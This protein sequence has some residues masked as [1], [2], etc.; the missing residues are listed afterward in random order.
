[1][2]NHLDKCKSD[3]LFV[4]DGMAACARASEQLAYRFARVG[5]RFGQDVRGP[6][7]DRGLDDPD[8]FES[9]VLRA[10]DKLTAH[11]GSIIVEPLVVYLRDAI[12]TASTPKE[13]DALMAMVTES[14]GWKDCSTAAYYAQRAHK[15]AKKIQKNAR[16]AIAS[17]H[18]ALGRK[19]LAREFDNLQN[20]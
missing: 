10:S 11:I 7:G 13:I 15:A 17:P 3:A 4:L 6:W 1:M 16:A 2:A 8:S 20:M 5:G 9:H 18:T 19:R 14:K 12:R